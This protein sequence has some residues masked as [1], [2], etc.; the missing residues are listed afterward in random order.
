MLASLR[1]G[2][3]KKA[4]KGHATALVIS[5]NEDG[6]LKLTDSR[7]LSATGLVYTV[8][9]V[10]L[11]VAIGF[12]GI[13]STLKGAK[14]GVHDLRER[15][16]HGG[17]DEQ[18]VHAI[19]A[20]AGPKAA[21]VLV[22]C[23]DQELRQAVVARATDHATKAGTARAHSSL[24]ASTRAV[25]TTGYGAP[26]ARPPDGTRSD[27]SAIAIQA[28]QRSCGQADE[29]PAA[30]TRS[31]VTGLPGRALPRLSASRADGYAATSTSGS[32]SIRRKSAGRVRLASQY[33]NPT[34]SPSPHRVPASRL[35]LSRP[36]PNS[37]GSSQTNPSES[38]LGRFGP[39]GL[40]FRSL[41]RR[42]V[43]ACPCQAPASRSRNPRGENTG[44]CPSSER[45]SL[46]PET[47]A[48]RCVD[49][50]AIR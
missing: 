14:G 19:L 34:I 50:R 28:K 47:R 46:S 39:V 16:A 2:F 3:R 13:F 42:M 20:K 26:W 17:S 21:L 24:L 12:M 4:R 22:C 15:E 29:A 44:I 8:M 40:L 7:V 45:R 43:V 41:R 31:K 23:D 49:A 48:T 35:R 37:D 6:S 32:G 33:S 38:P 27:R 30:P 10:A 36:R 18:A 9:R 1:R 11:S 5:G 25:R